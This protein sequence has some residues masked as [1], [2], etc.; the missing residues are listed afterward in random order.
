MDEADTAAGCGAA[1]LTEP[2]DGVGRGVPQHPQGAL[3][4]HGHPGSVGH[5]LHHGGQGGRHG[6]RRMGAVVLADGQGLLAQ[7]VGLVQEQEVLGVELVG[8]QVGAPRPGVVRGHEDHQRLVE[9][10]DG[11]G[12]LHVHVNGQDGGVQA[13][14]LQEG[15]D[16]AGGHLPQLD[17]QLGQQLGQAVEDHRGQVGGQGG[18]HAQAYGA[19]QGRALVGGSLAEALGRQDGLARERQEGLPQGGDQD[20]AGGA[21]HELTAH[22]PLQGVDRL[23]EA[24]LADAEARRGLTEVLVVAQCHEGAQLREGGQWGRGHRRGPVIK[25]GVSRPAA[26]WDGFDYRSLE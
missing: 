4:H 3:G 1:L 17:P 12:P 10:G 11:G 13:P 23:G 22:A 24:G 6:H 2:G 14:L 20:L 7:A 16:V 18:D 9:H 19:D 21:L 15:Q 8:A 25:G 5:H 26:L